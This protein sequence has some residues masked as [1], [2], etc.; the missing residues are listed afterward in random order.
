MKTKLTKL[1]DKYSTVQQAIERRRQGA[2]TP[3]DF[4]LLLKESE[5]VAVLHRHK[6]FFEED[7][8]TVIKRHK[9]YISKKSQ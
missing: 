4:L 1:I 7:Y 5:T 6:T 2:E 8:S 9:E 3:E